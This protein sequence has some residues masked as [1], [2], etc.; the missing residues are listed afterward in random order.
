M[1][2]LA[3]DATAWETNMTSKTGSGRGPDMAANDIGTLQAF[4]DDINPMRN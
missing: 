4:S 1:E 3:V 2:P